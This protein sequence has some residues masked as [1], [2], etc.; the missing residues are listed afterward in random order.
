MKP[1]C[2]TS[3]KAKDIE[4]GSGKLRSGAGEKFVTLGL[5]VTLGVGVWE[6]VVDGYVGK[7]KD[8]VRVIVAEIVVG[9]IGIELSVMGSKGSL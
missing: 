6:A 4:A 1:Q 5:H 3:N 7:G 8:W 9:P 2:A